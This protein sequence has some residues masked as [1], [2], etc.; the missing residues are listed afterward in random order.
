MFNSGGEVS[1]EREGKT[2]ALSLPGDAIRALAIER[3]L[4]VR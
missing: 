1:Q 4:A 2:R 3:A